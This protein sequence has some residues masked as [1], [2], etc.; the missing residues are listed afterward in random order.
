MYQHRE[1]TAVRAKGVFRKITLQPERIQKLFDAC[2]ILFHMSL[3]SITQRG[4]MHDSGRDLV[5]WAT[6]TVRNEK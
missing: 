3:L 4:I 5:H 6:R 2:N 1:I